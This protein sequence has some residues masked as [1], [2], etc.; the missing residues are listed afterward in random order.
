[1]K[2]PTKK[3]REEREVKVSVVAKKRR[4]SP[5]NGLEPVPD[6]LRQHVLDRKINWPP[7]SSQPMSESWLTY[8]WFTTCRWVAE[9]RNLNPKIDMRPAFACW[10]PGPQQRYLLATTGLPGFPW[11]VAILGYIR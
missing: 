10:P 6:E 1:M 4:P 11:P 7:W 2:K 9:Y 8:F 5:Y 3:K